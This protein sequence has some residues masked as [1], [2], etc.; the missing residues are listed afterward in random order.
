M[1]GREVFE[2]LRFT[3]KERCTQEPTAWNRERSQYIQ[4]LSEEEVDFWLHIQDDLPIFS[5]FF[6]LRGSHFEFEPDVLLT[7]NGKRR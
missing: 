1:T 5:S 7:M 4:L 2:R 6:V 3:W